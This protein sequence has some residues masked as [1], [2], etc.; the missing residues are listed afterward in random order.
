MNFDYSILINDSSAAAHFNIA[1]AYLSIERHNQAIKHFQN[2]LDL[3]G[4]SQRHT[5]MGEAYEQQKNLNLQKTV[6]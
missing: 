6:T 2:S 1:S 4:E 3:D 5:V